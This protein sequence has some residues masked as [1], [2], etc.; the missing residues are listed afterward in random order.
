MRRPKVGGHDVIS[1]VMK[2]FVVPKVLPQISNVLSLDGN[3][4]QHCKR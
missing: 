3:A 4:D 2:F 1:L